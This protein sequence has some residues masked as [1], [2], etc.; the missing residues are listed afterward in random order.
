MNVIVIGGVAAGTKTAAKLM[1]QDRSATVTIYTKSQDI[2]YAGCG[3]PY[4]VGGDIET[5]EELIVNTPASF[6]GLTGVA[7]RTGMEAVSVNGAEKTVTF[8]NGETVGYDKL[9]IATGAAPF[10][11]DVPGKDLPGVFTMRTPDDAIDL[12]AYVEQHSCRSAVVVG[13]GFIGLEIAENLMAKGVSVTVVDMAS[14]VLPNLFDA[15]MAAYIRRKLQAK[16]MRVITGAGLEEVQGTDK[17]TGV[18][19]TLG[20]FAGELVVLA[21]GVRPATGFLAGSGI[22]MNRGTIVVDKQQRTNIGDIYAVGDCAQVY[23][24]LTGSSQWSAMGSTAN[25][26]G[27]L[28]AKNLTWANLTYGGCLGTGVVRLANDLNAGHTGLTEAQAQAAGYDVITATCVTDDKAHYYP[29]ASTFVTKLIADRATHALLG[30]QVLGS[31][32]VDKMVDIAVTG[33]S[34]GMKLEDF[35]TLDYAYAPPFSTVIHPFVQAC[36]ILENKLSGA[37][38]SF[39]P[40]EYAAGKAKGYKV[41]D[42]SPAPAIPGAQW[43]NLTAVNGPL[44]GIDK[45]EKLLLVCAKGKRGYLLQNRLKAFGYT[46]TRALEGGLFVNEVKVEFTGALPAAEIKRVK[47][48]GCL[49]DKSYPDVFNVR[50]IARNGK[51]TAEEHRI[52]AEAAERFGS[53]EVTMTTRLTLEI[54]GVKYADLQTVMD[55]LHD[56]GLETGGTGSLVRPVVSCK[57]T[58]CQY[59]LIDTFGLSERLH[60]AFY[61]GYHG[62]TLPHKFKIAVGGCPNNCVKPNLNDLGIVGQR[63]P[64]IDYAK[65]RGCKKCRVE[66]TCP[67]KVARVED[68]KIKI[69]PTQCNNCGRCKNQCVFGALDYQDGYRIYIGGRWGKKVAH[70]QPLTR[71]FTSEEEVMGVVERAILLFRDEGQTGERFADTVTRLGFD[72][73]NQ[74][75]LDNTMDKEAILK[76]T[77]KGGATC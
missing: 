1:R 32:A 31:G 63:V 30:I 59:G 29:D 44:D 25:L 77:V 24:S 67:I 16:G 23:N 20:T 19:T 57:G 69:G 11:P 51:I 58:T 45:D 6:T 13:G 39:T 36:Y 53:G 41:I 76:K 8:A 35:D 56:H 22:E 18:R 12:R 47:A 71:I 10:V 74:K 40:A 75:L 48:L 68:G 65:C 73:V 66:A 9:V 17:A 61:V 72:Y 21:I 3:L 5:R 43:V 2:S 54:Q 50:V 26:T 70:G 7:V 52:I 64:M 42:A 62:V 49:Q 14:Q 46:N 60:E 55:F 28:L 15:E 38:E 27:R 33:I 37:Y 34:A 4:Y